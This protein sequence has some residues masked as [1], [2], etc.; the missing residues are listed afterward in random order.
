MQLTVWG[1]RGSIPVSG[2]EYDRYGGDTTCVCMETDAGDTVILDAGTGL[3]P[4]GN[5]LLNEKK[6]T[7]HFVLSHAH[8]DH[9]LGFPF[10]KPLYREGVT[11]FVH[12]C[13]YAQQSI[14]NF[15]GTVM[16]PPFFP[17]TLDDVHANLVFDDECRPDFEVG[18]LCCESIPLSHPNNGYGFRFTEGS[19][20]V[21]FFP[22]NEFTFAHPGGKSRGEYVE[23]LR[24]V[25]LLVHDSEYL[26]EEYESY[27]RGWGHSVYSDTI[28]MAVDA[29]VQR[30]VLWHLNQDRDDDGVDALLALAQQRAN[31]AGRDD[32]CVMARTGLVLD[33]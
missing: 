6:N 4:L 21:G 27:T 30:L 12:G 13:T 23:F 19:K 18:S 7:F 17:V 3:R 16:Q 31:E 14:R 24:G 5:S 10:F 15:L 26:P 8:W 29:E 32:L 22:D 11:I 9:L 25:D 2:V 20:S 33:V 28:D 1:A